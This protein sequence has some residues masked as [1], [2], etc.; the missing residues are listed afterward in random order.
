M[1]ILR[2]Y[3]LV[4]IAGWALWLWLDKTPAP[5]RAA[6]GTGPYA[7]APMPGYPGYGPVPGMGTIP[8]APPEEGIV[9][10]LQYSVNLLKAGRLKESF[11]FLWR[12]QSWLVAGVLT[13]FI[14]LLLPGLGGRLGHLRRRLRKRPADAP[15]PGGESGDNQT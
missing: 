13:A 1:G 6:P 2:T 10:E 7:G 8:A 15:P 11:V 14:T 12:R 3:A 4:F 9:G 5:Y